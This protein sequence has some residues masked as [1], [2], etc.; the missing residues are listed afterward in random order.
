MLFGASVR[1]GHLVHIERTVDDRQ[2]ISGIMG[3]H[4]ASP[5]DVRQDDRSPEG[6]PFGPFLRESILGAL[7]DDPAQQTPSRLP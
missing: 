6:D 2:A 1:G 4:N 3:G 7:A 5:H